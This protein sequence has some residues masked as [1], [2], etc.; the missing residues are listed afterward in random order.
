MTKISGVYL[1][2]F[3]E[4]VAGVRLV[5]AARAT[6]ASVITTTTAQQSTGMDGSYSFDMLSGVYVVTAS[7]AY[8]GVIN[9]CPDSPDG[10]LNNYLT[11]FSADELTPAALAEIQELVKEARE[12]AAAAQSCAVAAETSKTAAAGSASA[13]EASAG[14][15]AASAAAAKESADQ[16]NSI[17]SPGDPGTY[18]FAATQAFGSGTIYREFGGTMNGSALMPAC[19]VEDPSGE[20]NWGVIK[21]KS[22]HPAFSGTWSCCGVAATGY[23]VSLWL[24]IDTPELLS[25][26]LRSGYRQQRVRNCCYA[27]ASNTAID[28][29]IDTVQGWLPFTASPNDSTEYGPKIYAA[30]IAGDYGDVSVYAG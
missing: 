1:N 29:E 22:V 15:A 25:T 23:G 7:G 30:A 27:N 3:G 18:V 8:L 20:T 26:K 6:S 11:N 5:L 19:V 28:C 10:T 12:A 24:R 9:V 21:N 14:D 16:A 2:G 13:A 17:K 4:P